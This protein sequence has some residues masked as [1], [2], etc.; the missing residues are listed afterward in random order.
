MQDAQTPMS[1]CS[2]EV[3]RQDE[4]KYYSPTTV[5]SQKFIKPLSVTC[6]QLAD[7]YLPNEPQPPLPKSSTPSRVFVND[8][9]DS[10]GEKSVTLKSEHPFADI[11]EYKVRTG[12][13]ASAHFNT[14]TIMI[15]D[16]FTFVHDQA[17][18]KVYSDF[19]HDAIEELG[20]WWRGVV[21]DNVR[22]GLRLCSLCRRV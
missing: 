15:A 22:G 13:A 5:K 1:E 19:L 7:P 16:G 21:L 14:K 4:A 8:T 20:E 18:N 11:K 12:M 6:N 17:D 2:Y 3:S 9:Q 10:S